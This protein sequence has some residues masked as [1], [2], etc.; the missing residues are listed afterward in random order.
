MDLPESSDSESI[1]SIVIPQRRLFSQKNNLQPTNFGEIMGKRD[2]LAELHKTDTDVDKT[3]NVRTRELFQTKQRSKQ[4]FPAA[5]LNISPNKTSTDK[6]ELVTG[7]PRAQVRNIFGNRA[8]KRKNIFSNFIVAESEDEIPEIESKV[9]NFQMKLDAHRQ[10]SSPSRGIRDSLAS[11]ITND[12]EMDDW[13]MLPSST[14]VENQLEILIADGNSSKRARLSKLTE[15]E[16]EAGSNS[17]KTSNKSV[18]S[19]GTVKSR[20]S[21]TFTKEKAPE[22]ETSMTTRNKSKVFQNDNSE[23][24]FGLNKDDQN[25]YSNDTEKSRK[26]KTFIKEKEPEVEIS[27]TTRNES[28]VSQNDNSEEEFELNKE[29]QN[30]YSNDTD[31]SRKSKTLIKEKAPE[32]EISMNTRNK[33]KASQN[34]DNVEEIF[35]QDQEAS[36]K[37]KTFTKEKAPE[38]ETSMTTR[39]KSKISQHDEEMLVQNQE[40]HKS[41]FKTVDQN[42]SQSS[43]TTQ[44]INDSPKSNQT[45]EEECV[46]NNIS[47]GTN[48]SMSKSLALNPKDNNVNIATEA[49]TAAEPADPLAAAD[50]VNDD[51]INLTLKYDNDHEEI[52]K[53]LENIQHYSPRDAQNYQSDVRNEESEVQNE[54]AIED[55]QSQKKA[56]EIV[57]NLNKSETIQDQEEIE[58]PSRNEDEHYESFLLDQ[59]ENENDEGDDIN[60]SQVAE[61]INEEEENESLEE[62]QNDSVVEQNESVVEQNESVVEQNESQ[63]QNERQEQNESQEHKNESVVDQ[64]ENENDEGDDIN[65]SQVAEDVNEEEENE[66]LEEQQN[67]SVVEQNESVVEQ[68]ESVVEQNESQDQNERQEQNESQEHK[69]ESVVDQN[70]SQENE[71]EIKRNES[72][73]LE[74]A[75]EE[76]DFVQ[77]ISQEKVEQD[78]DLEEVAQDTGEEDVEQDTDQDEVEQDTDIEEQNESKTENHDESEAV[79]DSDIEN[80]KES[81]NNISQ[82]DVANGSDEQVESDPENEEIETTNISHDTTGK[83]KKNESPE[84]VLR[85]RNNHFDSIAVQGRNTSVRKTEIIKSMHIR[86]SL[87]TLRESTS[88]SD[89]TKNSSAEGSGWDSHRTTRKTLRQTFGK[90]FTPRKSLR[91]LVMEKI[92]KRQTQINEIASGTAKLPQGNEASVTAK[93]PQAS[94]ASVT[95]NFRQ[96]NETASVTAKFPQAS[97]ASV[98]ANF[99][100]ANETAS[101]TAKFPVANSTE[102]PEMSNRYDDDDDDVENQESN[103]E[104]SL[105][106]RQTS[107]DMYLKEIKKKNAEIRLKIEEEVRNSLKAPPKYIFKVPA[108]P[109]PARRKPAAKP[110]QVSST[111]FMGEYSLPAEIIEDMKYKPPKRFQPNDAPWITKRLYNEAPARRGQPRR[112]RRAEARDGATA[113]R[114]DALRIL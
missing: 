104:V 23:E 36:R 15:I 108:R 41:N 100:Q 81:D 31:K 97:P 71:S 110:R 50:Q 84:V 59:S 83:N 91:A 73:E 53:V 35:G 70:E 22:V 77:N 28:K 94:P 95:A 54:I 62:Q 37:S 85:N 56:N 12:M 17:T 33:S 16:S 42:L 60:E 26:S 57:E 9:F 76:D 46:L 113:H 44:G 111:I 92:A 67:D 27:M 89:S 102:L 8:T 61:D 66:S 109:P 87:A 24:E 101:V 5:L 14:L 47:K 80:D 52:E 78:T 25:K 39:Q 30:K 63:D 88:F 29:D 43:I 40:A 10:G 34:D 75:D 49:L 1:R 103:H 68:N 32:V 69:N 2:T 55:S 64:S 18:S 6:T 38:L 19:K 107:L 3:I 93:L 51:E 74:V 90:D 20:K 86:P 65:E 48:R 99:R 21:K 45:V 106:T 13:K 112:R 105:R 4:I 114:E 7:E 79:A 96:A 98:T 72:Q 58:N 11:S 82:D